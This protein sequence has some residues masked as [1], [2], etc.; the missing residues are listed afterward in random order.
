[1]TKRQI[2]PSCGKF[3]R[4]SRE[5]FADAAK[6]SGANPAIRAASFC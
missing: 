2:L 6:A 3:C 4:V 5:E 1:M